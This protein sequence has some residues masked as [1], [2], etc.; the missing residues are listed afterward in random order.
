MNASQV[1][2]TKLVKIEGPDGEFG[3][4]FYGA[5]R[6]GLRYLYQDSKHRFFFYAEVKPK[7]VWTVVIEFERVLRLTP[8]EERALEHNI[9]HFF[10]TRHFL[11]PGQ[12]APPGGDAKIVTFQW[13][14]VR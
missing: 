11:H 13:G 14:V 6:E 4:A 9:E 8:D 1:G 10:K 7:P 5:N 12:E 2:E 3:I